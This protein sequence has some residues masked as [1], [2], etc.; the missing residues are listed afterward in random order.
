[1][2]QLIQVFKYYAKVRL[3]N[4]KPKSSL[5]LICLGVVCSVSAAF[6]LHLW[7]TN[8]ELEKE[9]QTLKTSESVLI[10][11]RNKLKPENDFLKADNIK[12]KSENNQLK[13]PELFVQ[14]DDGLSEPMP[15]GH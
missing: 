15:G 14:E 4:S 2:I 3:M 11:F 10:I 7:T 6:N 13:N 9:N 8:K 1:M 5:P 12:L